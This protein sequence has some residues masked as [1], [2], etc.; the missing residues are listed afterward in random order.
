MQA[1]SFMKLIFG[2]CLVLSLLQYCEAVDFYGNDKF[3]EVGDI[4]NISIR[5]SNEE[6][7]STLTFSNPQYKYSVLNFQEIYN[8]FKRVE[9]EDVSGEYSIC[10]G[11]ECTSY[12]INATPICPFFE[13][14]V[15]PEQA[16]EGQELF[17][18]TI[19]R[20]LD[21]LYYL[22]DVLLESNRFIAKP[23]YHKIK[24]VL[25]SRCV[26]KEM[27]LTIFVY[28]KEF[29]EIK[30]IN[31]VSEMGSQKDINERHLVSFIVVGLLVIAIIIGLFLFKRKNRKGIALSYIIIGAIAIVILVVMITLFVSNA[32]K[33]QSSYQEVF[34]SVGKYRLCNE[35]C[36]QYLREPC[37]AGRDVISTED[38]QY[39]HTIHTQMGF[40]DC[41]CDMEYSK[42]VVYQMP[43]KQR[44]N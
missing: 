34:D 33:Q 23:G 4:I 38:Y 31:S 25:D 30:E 10:V 13:F 35:L 41:S 8:H 18:Q 12:K 20:E 2:V 42:P 22:E 15:L 1:K 37:N 44:G 5:F 26:N 32:T 21:Y 19:P 3:Y 17:I 36:N 6:L 28:P 11:A 29:P 14:N 39:C 7:P 9:S 16:Y 24:V 40:E 43:G 27:G